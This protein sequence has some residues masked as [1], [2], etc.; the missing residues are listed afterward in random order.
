MFALPDGA[1]PQDLIWWALMTH[2]G[3]E[4]MMDETGM[5]HF[6]VK[7]SATLCSACAGCC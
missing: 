6:V 1:D 5:I 3:L 2:P 4:T 7:Q